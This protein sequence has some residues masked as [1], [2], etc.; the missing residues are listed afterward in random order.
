MVAPAGGNCDLCLVIIAPLRYRPRQGSRLLYRR[1][2]YLIATDPD[3][4]PQ[5]IVEHYLWRWDSE[6]NFRDEKTLLGVRTGAGQTSPLGRS[7]AA[8]DRGCLRL[9]VAGGAPDLGP[10]GLPRRPA[11]AA[12][13]RAPLQAPRHDAR[14]DPAPAGRAVGP[15]LASFLRLPPPPY[16]PLPPRTPSERRSTRSAG[17]S[18]PNPFSGSFLDWKMLR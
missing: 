4:S 5:P 14:S 2:A 13:A 10:G 3:L 8:V 6:V 12:V 16:P 11:A 7:G 17:P 9:V 18:P 1:P 15:R